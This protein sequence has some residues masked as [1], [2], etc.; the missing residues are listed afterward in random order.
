MKGKKGTGSG[1]GLINREFGIGL[2]CRKAYP[3]CQSPDG[4][5][6]QTNALKTWGAVTQPGWLIG[7]ETVMQPHPFLEN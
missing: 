1:L 3:F 2:T 5:F 7:D 6:A 4:Y